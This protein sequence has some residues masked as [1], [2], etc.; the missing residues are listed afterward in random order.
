MQLGDRYPRLEAWI[1]GW[2][3]CRARREEVAALRRPVVRRR[4]GAPVHPTLMHEIARYRQADMLREAERARLAHQASTEA[5]DP[6]PLAAPARAHGLQAGARTVAAARYR[7]ADAATA[8]R[9]ASVAASASR[10]ACRTRSSPG[11]ETRFAAT[12][13]AAERAAASARIDAAAASSAPP[14]HAC[15]A[16]SAPEKG[17]VVGALGD[18]ERQLGSG[19]ERLADRLVAPAVLR[20]RPRSARAPRGTPP[21]SPPRAARRASEA[22]APGRRRP[23]PRPTLRSAGPPRRSTRRHRDH[24]AR[25]G[26]GAGAGEGPAISSSMTR[27]SR[28]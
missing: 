12:R 13:P 7:A 11:S 4:K 6:A 15:C 22:P 21:R 26:T 20:A 2:T 5:E 18:R 23:C 8:R 9:A 16:A 17:D 24:D 25:D 1:A 3:T 19:I 14:R 28:S 27:R 10:C